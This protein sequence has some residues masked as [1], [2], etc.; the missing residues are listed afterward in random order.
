MIIKMMYQRQS[1]TKKGIC[2]RFNKTVQ[3]KFYAIAF[4]KIYT[5]IKQLQ[6]NLK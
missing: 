5:S 3:N 1:I 6:A 4:K 2:E